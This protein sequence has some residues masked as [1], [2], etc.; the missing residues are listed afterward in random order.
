MKIR[1]LAILLACLM[2]MLTACQPVSGGEGTQPPE[3]GT[4]LYYYPPYTYYD[5][6]RDHELTYPSKS[7]YYCNRYD[8]L[9][10]FLK[11]EKSRE[12]TFEEWG[13][14]W[15]NYLDYVKEVNT[16][17]E[18]DTPLYIPYING[19]PAILHPSLSRDGSYHGI[20]L[21]SVGVEGSPPYVEYSIDVGGEEPLLISCLC[22]SEKDFALVDVQTTYDAA[23]SF[24]PSI[25]NLD[26]CDTIPYSDGYYESVFEETIQISGKSVLALYEVMWEWPD[27]LHFVFDKTLVTIIGP[28]E[29]LTNRDFIASISLQKA[30]LP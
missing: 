10:A 8:E 5:Y 22:L 21:V 15:A 3:P 7:I 18:N 14:N 9:V 6:G 12:K 2:V 26:D 1:F 24:D 23:R 28:A 25:P 13:A 27:L 4:T 19:E 11:E 30:E 20:R 16:P 29:L 17:S